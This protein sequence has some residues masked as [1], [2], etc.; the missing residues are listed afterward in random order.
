MLKN[1]ETPFYNCEAEQRV[2]IYLVLGGGG[3]DTWYFSCICGK[4][5]L[6]FK[7]EGNGYDIEHSLLVMHEYLWWT[8]WKLRKK[9]TITSW[10]SYDNL[11]ESHSITYWLFCSRRQHFQTQYLSINYHHR[12]VFLLT[13]ESPASRVVTNIQYMVGQLINKRAGF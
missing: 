12:L 9:S 11:R 5:L 10:L 7:R 6:S 13:A 8:R 4:S 3:E 1:Q 2:R